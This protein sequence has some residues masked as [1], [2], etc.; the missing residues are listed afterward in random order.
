MMRNYV[1]ANR[2]EIITRQ[3]RLSGYNLLAGPAKAERAAFL[4][5]FFSYCWQVGPLFRRSWSNWSRAN[6]ASPEPAITSKSTPTP[7]PASTAKPKSPPKS[8]PAPKP[9]VPS[10]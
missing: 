8:T 3:H 4:D 9:L 7:S 2:T 1:S 6:P 10:L 5:R